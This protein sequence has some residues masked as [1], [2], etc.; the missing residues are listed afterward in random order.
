MLRNIWFSYEFFC[1]NFGA[2]HPILGDEEPNM[3]VTRANLA[4]DRTEMR[5]LAGQ[6]AGIDLVLSI[7]H[8]LF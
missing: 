8:R 2:A 3:A 1:H 7:K 6:P 5:L 4:L